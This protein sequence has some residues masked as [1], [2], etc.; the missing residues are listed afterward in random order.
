MRQI[1]NWQALHLFQTFFGAS[2]TG[3]QSVSIRSINEGGIKSIIEW[4]EYLY[5]C[6]VLISWWMLAIA[7]AILTGDGAAR[8]GFGIEVK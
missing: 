1:L 3:L 6:P 2:L 8:I 5:W 7:Q 4:A